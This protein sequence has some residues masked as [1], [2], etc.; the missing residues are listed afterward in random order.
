[1]QRLDRA[2]AARPYDPD[3]TAFHTLG[4][5]WTHSRARYDA[6]PEA[7]RRVV[8]ALPAVASDP[9][10]ARAAC[11]H[12]RRPCDDDRAA[13]GAIL[14]YRKQMRRLGVPVL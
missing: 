3:V 7:V 9:A 2:R 12:A 4:L 13:A 1:M 10:V 11:D 5:A 14:R 8:A 6:E